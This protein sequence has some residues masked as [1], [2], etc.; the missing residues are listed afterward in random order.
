M[1]HKING[2]MGFGDCFKNMICKIYPGDG[3]AE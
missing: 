3:V 2:K 1:P